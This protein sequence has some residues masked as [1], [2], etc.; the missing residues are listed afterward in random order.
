[1]SYLG[2]T[3]EEVLVSI[4]P[5]YGFFHVALMEGLGGLMI[6]SEMHGRLLQSGLY[7]K[8]DK[9]IVCILGDQQQAHTLLDYVFSRYPKYLVQYVSPN[10]NLWEWPTLGCLRDCCRDNPESDV[11]YIHTKGASNC[12]PDVPQ[13]LQSNIRNWRGVM[14][15]EIMN[16]A[17][18]CKDMLAS[19][20]DAVGP[21]L[22][23]DRPS[24]PHFVGNFWWATAAHI[25][26]LPPLSVED[27]CGRSF[28]ENWVGGN[29][30]A[31]LG[32]LVPLLAYDCYDFQGKFFPNG[33]FEGYKGSC[34]Y[35]VSPT[36]FTLGE[37]ARRYG[38]DKIDHGFIKPYADALDSRRESVKRVLE[39]GVHEGR[40]LQM[41]R[42]YFPNALVEGWDILSFPENK[43]GPR[44]TTRVVNQEDAISILS[45][46]A[47]VA[48]GSYD[49]IIDDGAH[50]M[51][52]QQISLATLWPYLA[53]GGIFIVED[54]HTSLPHN[55]YEW[56]GGKCKEDFSNSTLRALQR[57][58]VA[59]GMISEYMTQ[60]QMDMISK[61]CLS[62]SVI[63]AKNDERH[64]TSI[65][66]KILD[67]G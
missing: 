15:H 60:E 12:R 36:A 54:L 57:L 56:A 3:D 51:S 47:N 13:Y 40:S 41:W 53:P 26:S 20:Y 65:L 50:T 28:A 55:P 32:N 64:I 66:F 27:I 11:W 25:N 2:K 7:D 5:T 10:L 21:L 49:L 63:D 43:F 31:K 17:D 6:A 48:H 22:S 61:E 67:K 24:G 4:K 42:D 33:V 39:I 16:R 37:I 1:M 45:A 62:C 34:I 44:T 19:G 9:I 23:T 18:T 52:G 46:M 59:Q 14:C 29:P 30:K 58:E 8:T 38:T 35:P